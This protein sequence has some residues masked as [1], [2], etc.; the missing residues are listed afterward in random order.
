MRAMLV[1]GGTRP[2]RGDYRAVRSARRR[3][4]GARP[5]V[6]FVHWLGDDATTN[7]TEFEADAIALASAARSA[8]CST[9]CGRRCE[10]RRNACLKRPDDADD[11]ANSIRQVVD[12][13]RG[14]DLLL[15]YDVDPQRIAYV[16]HDFGA[17]Y[18]RSRGSRCASK[19]LR[20]NAGNPSFSQW[21]CSARNPPTCGLRKA[22]GAADPLPIWRVR[23]RRVSCSSSHRTTTTFHLRTRWRCSSRAGCAAFF[24]TMRTWA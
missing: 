22:D 20:A 1:F 4:A 18:E 21:Y 11:Y 17:M 16:G 7:H 9:R 5:G 15:S 10:R 19:L 12:L 2:K 24:S 13:R 6:L 14:I 23:P 3:R 8:F